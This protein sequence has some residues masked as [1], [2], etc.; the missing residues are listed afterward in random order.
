MEEEEGSGN[1]RPD[2]PLRC[3]IWQVHH[4][5][6]IPRKVDADGLIINVNAPQLPSPEPWP[7]HLNVSELSKFL[8]VLPSPACH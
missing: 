5:T 8:E 4:K 2:I 7:S 1:S 3:P 6:G